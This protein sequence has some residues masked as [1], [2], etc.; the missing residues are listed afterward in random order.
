MKLSF[1]II[2]IKKVTKN[3]IAAFVIDILHNNIVYL[4]HSFLRTSKCDITWHD[5]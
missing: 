1:V 2:N 5:L 3:K 4:N